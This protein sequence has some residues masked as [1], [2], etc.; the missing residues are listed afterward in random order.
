MFAATP[1]VT[2]S[3]EL[4]VRR[5]LDLRE[6]V[7]GSAPHPLF[8]GVSTYRLVPGTATPTLSSIVTGV[9][10]NARATMVITGQVLWRLGNGGLTAP[11]TP[12]IAIDYLF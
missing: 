8:A 9:K 5:L 11:L 3:G 2:V 7:P 1:R 12:T 10:W 6:V 4:L